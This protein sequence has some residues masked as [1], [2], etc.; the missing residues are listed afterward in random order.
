MDSHNVRP[1]TK[2][3]RQKLAKRARHARGEKRASTKEYEKPTSQQLWLQELY[4]PTL[5]DVIRALQAGQPMESVDVPKLDGWGVAF[6]I[7]LILQFFGGAYASTREKPYQ[8][9]RVSPGQ[10]PGPDSQDQGNAFSVY[11]DYPVD[12]LYNVFATITEGNGLPFDS[13]DAIQSENGPTKKQAR[14]KRNSGLHRSG[15][16]TGHHPHHRHDQLDPQ[17]D[18]DHKRHTHR[19]NGAE[20]ASHHLQ[21][22]VVYPEDKLSPWMKNVFN[23]VESIVSLFGPA[24]RAIGFEPDEPIEVHRS[25]SGMEHIPMPSKNVTAAEFSMHLTT[26]GNEKFRLKPLTDRGRELQRIVTEKGR[27]GENNFLAKEVLNPIK[28]KN[29]EEGMM[30]IG[31]K[32]MDIDRIFLDDTATLYHL[33]GQ[34][35]VKVQLSSSY[36]AAIKS[37]LGTIVKI[38]GPGGTLTRYFAIVPHHPD[39]VIQVPDPNS[40]ERWRT[41][42]ATTGKHLFFSDPSIFP[43]GSTFLAE[44]QDISGLERSAGVL[45]GAVH[46]TIE[47]IVDGTMKHM[48]EL[49]SHETLAEGALNKILGFIP[50]Y[51]FAR[52]VRNGQYKKAVV[53]LSFDLIP[54][55]G[56]GAKILFKT[57]FK[58]TPA[59]LAADQVAKWADEGFE[60]LSKSSSG[61]V[62]DT[63]AD[64]LVRREQRARQRPVA[65]GR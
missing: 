15:H 22:S 32:F 59:R 9:P 8:L 14:F 2:K 24:L 29:I 17:H 42:M 1:K 18:S 55:V 19:R 5:F 58:S 31:N 20:E 37:E 21:D 51:D 39:M 16:S 38:P 11:H 3:S 65:R 4:L 45:R 43:G 36:V 40:K 33:K 53:F 6:F 28:R 62:A 23:S 61:N 54:Y 10:K 49:V 57:I 63:V 47:P 46:H 52:S 35:P 12:D 64:D 7:M 60:V 41:W 30:A 56:K 48:T 50:F 44:E 27:Y 25:V 34:M 26:E 13:G